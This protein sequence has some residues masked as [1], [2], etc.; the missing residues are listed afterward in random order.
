M[1]KHLLV[2][3]FFL[4]A[5]P[6][7]SNYRLKSF[8]FSG[9]GGV[10]SS[11]NYSMESVLGEQG[12]EPMSSSNYQA[13]PG[14]L[15]VQMANVP[16]AP[17]LINDGD[18][19][20]KLRITVD[21]GSNPSDT[22][23]AI[24]VSDDS[25]VTTKYVQSDNTLGDTLGA[26]DWQTY[27]NWG[28]ASG[29]YIVGLS[30]GTTYEAKVK[31]SHG[32]YTDSPFGPTDSATTSNLTISFDLD[33]SSSDTE[34]ASPYALAFGDLNIGS[35]TTSSDKIWIDISTNAS[36]GGMVYVYGS[37]G[38]LVST[39]TSNTISSVSGNLTALDDGFGLQSSSVAQ[40]SGGPLAA[41]SPFNGASENIGGVTTS[42]Q[43]IYNSSA[44]PITAGRG[45]LLV[46]A[47]ASSLT[48]AASDY[49]ET[50]TLVAAGNF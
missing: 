44:S 4:L 3:S 29:E 45:S 11:S 23:F 16:P 38:G 43:E 39:A 47:K 2:F 36:S 15:Y 37:N 12:A 34:T 8:T 28:G 46:K 31:A 7:S 40:G 13:V 22:V 32:S 26:E 25:F 33:V 41:T 48:P 30:P 9:G 20:N 49:T 18:Y 19:Y 17:T 27:T 21:A 14:L 6:A 50:I 5:Y 35:V 1:K 24:A 10:S 42:I